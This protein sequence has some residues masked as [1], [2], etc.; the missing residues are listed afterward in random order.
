MAKETLVLAL[1]SSLLCPSL[2]L[3]CDPG[4]TDIPGYGCYLFT[5]DLDPMSW[6]D[7]EAFCEA[8]GGYLA[9]MRDDEHQVAMM[10]AASGFGGDFWVGLTDSEE[11]GTFVWGHAG[12]EGDRF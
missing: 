8:E 3:T 5:T 9:E 10:E 7:A 6:S 12:E 4:W 1:I 11:E 2:G